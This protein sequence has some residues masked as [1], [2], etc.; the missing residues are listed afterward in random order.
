LPTVS[1]GAIAVGTD[2]TASLVIELSQSS[3]LT[4]AR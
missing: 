3:A 1:Q 4:N 2:F